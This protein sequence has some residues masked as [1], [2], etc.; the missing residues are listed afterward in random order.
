MHALIVDDEYHAAA[1]LEELI[2]RHCPEITSIEILDDSIEALKSLSKSKPDLLFLDIEMPGLSGFDLVEA[3][4]ES[5]LPPVI[6]ITAYQK[7][8][9]Q[10]FEYAALHYLLKP[11]APEKLVAAVH[12]VRQVHAQQSYQE[13]TEGLQRFSTQSATISLPEGLDYHIIHLTDILRVEGSGSY[14]RFFLRN[15]REIMVSKRLK[16]YADRL[17][18][19]GFI[20]SHQSHVVNRK[21]IRKYSRAD[22]G[23]LLLEDGSSVPVSP[24]MRAELK[25]TL[26][27]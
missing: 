19:Q 3:L 1:L 8:A 9:S 4:P 27:L 16:V 15:G 13:L 22:G 12:R 10:A 26:Q 14:A 6:F 11:V 21:C 7:Y 17:C 25:D 18:Q 2:H 5:H 23:F 20:R 24:K